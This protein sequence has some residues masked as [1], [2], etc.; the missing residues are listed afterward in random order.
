MDVEGAQTWVYMRVHKSMTEILSCLSLLI[1]E[2]T[3]KAKD[4]SL[5]I[6]CV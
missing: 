6:K 3:E 1:R 5:R 2:N 4:R